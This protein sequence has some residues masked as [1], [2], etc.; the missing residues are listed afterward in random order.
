MTDDLRPRSHWQTLI[1]TAITVGTSVWGGSQWLHNRASADDV[2]T[3]TN[4]S[5]QQRLD[6]EAVKGDVKAIYIQM[7]ELRSEVKSVNKKLDD[8]PR[9]RR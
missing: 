3:L 4:N 6:L 8:E 1:A 9:R 7:S 5:F 2:K